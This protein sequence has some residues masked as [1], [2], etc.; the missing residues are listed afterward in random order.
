M[1]VNCVLSTTSCVLPGEKLWIIVYELT[2]RRA[3]HGVTLLRTLIKN[4]GDTMEIFR[5]WL[6]RVLPNTQAI[7]L[8][9]LLVLGF[10]VVATLSEMMMPVFAAAV[11][12][13]LLEGIVAY[14]ERKRVPR[15]PAVLVVYFSFLAFVLYVVTALLPL[16]YQQAMQ[17]FLQLPYMI[18]EAQR[19]VMQL[20][21][22]YPTFIT[23]GQIQEII[24][25]MRRD[26]VSYGQ[27]VLSYSYTKLIGVATVTVYLILMPL[28]IFFFLKD[29]SKIMDWFGQYLPRER[30][31][32]HEVWREVD[33]QIGNYIRGKFFEIVTLGGI[34]YVTF[35]LMGLNYPALLAVSNGLSVIIPYVGATLVTVP[36]LMV[37]YFQ[38]GFSH[39]FYYLLLA[40]AV[41]QT[42]DGVLLVPLL[43]SE[44]VNLHPVAIIVAILFFG[45]LWGFWGVFFAIPLATLVQAVLC[46]WPRAGR[47][48]NQNA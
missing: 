7:S 26:L 46:A 27:N 20:P 21:E 19:G 13:Y 36:V 10:V 23:E 28:L 41:I 24:A 47:E 12:A 16:L 45:G 37:A 2:C 34:S 15:A 5:D 9:V 3:S 29:K 8:S 43:F 33:T 38:W 25:A 1:C 11:L 32:S 39:D 42:L 40:Y 48:A 14:G 22:R 44:V 30:H 31:L 35:S 18:N 17:L 4:N 6:K